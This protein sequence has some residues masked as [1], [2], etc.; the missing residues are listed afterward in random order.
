MISKGENSDIKFWLATVSIIQML[1]PLLNNFYFF[2]K[3]NNKI[4]EA[5]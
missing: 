1:I 3:N 5:G 4:S 2:L